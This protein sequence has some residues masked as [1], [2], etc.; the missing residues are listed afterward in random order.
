LE[1]ISLKNAD[2][3]PLVIDLKLYIKRTNLAAASASVGKGRTTLEIV[4]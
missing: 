4:E 3:T 1:K 2:R